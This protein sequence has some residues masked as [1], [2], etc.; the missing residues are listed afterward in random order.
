VGG[1]RG[2][3]GVAETVVGLG[4]RDVG[5]V[6]GFTSRFLFAGPVS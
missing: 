1:W 6:S 2:S 5:G 4:G 3:V